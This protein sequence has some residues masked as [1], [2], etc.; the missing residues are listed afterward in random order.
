LSNR[1][2]RAE[3]T[4]WSAGTQERTG[5]VLSKV[6]VDNASGPDHNTGVGSRGWRNWQTRYFEVVVSVRTCRFD[7]C[8]A[9]CLAQRQQVQMQEGRGGQ[10]AGGRFGVGWA[11]PPDFFNPCRVCTT[12]RSLANG[13]LLSHHEGHEGHECLRG[14]LWQQV[15]ETAK[16]AKYANGR[17]PKAAGRGHRELITGNWLPTG[18]RLQAT[19]YCLPTAK[20]AKYA[21][22]RRPKAVGRG[23]R[24]LTTGN[25]VF[26]PTTDY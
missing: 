2:T 6:L 15:F 11:S 18:Y 13:E 23:H 3:H 22:G 21:N 9:Q 19:D 7:S 1:Q 4:G 16:Y 8:P 14:S 10:Q 26:P 20:Y 24:E 17:R 12:R 5:G 25:S